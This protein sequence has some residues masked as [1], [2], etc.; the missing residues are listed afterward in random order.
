VEPA[1]APATRPATF[2]IRGQI[3]A[4]AG[5]DLQRPDLTRAVI[6]LANDP[7]LPAGPTPLPN[8]TMGQRDKTF[9]PSFLVIAKGTQVEFP[10]WD[11]ISHNV[12]SR[13]KAAPA[14]D[15]ERYPY[16][17]SKARTFDKVGVVQVFCNIHQQM[18]A[19]IVVTPNALFVRP[20]ADGQ[21]EL[22]NV[23]AGHHDL[24]VWQ[25]RC[26]DQHLAVDVQSQDLA[27]LKI[28]LE[29]SR[30]SIIAN[31]PPARHEGYGVERGLGVK[32]ERLNLPVVNDAHPSSQPEPK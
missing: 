24:V 28:S 25:E 14:F 15:L 22:K 8:A 1:P 26:E 11:H 32:R 21:F 17:W 31:D 10:N 30:R 3:T 5:W 6:Y 29:E 13:S 9:V 4:S 16:G 18:R 7:T 2:S 19:V 12:F 27:G 20:D 23:P